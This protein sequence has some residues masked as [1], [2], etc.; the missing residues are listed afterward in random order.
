MSDRTHER[1][2]RQLGYAFV[3]P[4]LLAQA[5]THRSFGG[6]HNERLE[7]L[8]DSVLGFIVSGLLFDLY[9]RAPEAELTLKRAQLVKRETLARIAAAIALGDALRF[10]AAVSGSGVQRRT[11]VLADGLEAVIGAVYLDGGSTAAGQVVRHLLRAE[12]ETLDSQSLKD[13]KTRL[14]EILQGEGRPLPVYAV[15]ATHGVEHARIYEVS[16]SVLDGPGGTGQGRSRRAAEQDAALQ[17]LR[18]LAHDQRDAD[19]AA[20]ATHA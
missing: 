1:L 4:S 18:Q 16:C 17:V 10:S 13:P 5:L 12:L 11:S 6:A 8:G 15:V 19:S 14:Q 2:Q 20:G 7:F 3:D 9:P